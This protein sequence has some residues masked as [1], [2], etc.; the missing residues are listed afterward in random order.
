MMAATTTR[1]DGCCLE[2]LTVLSG[3]SCTS[4]IGA[5]LLY[6]NAAQEPYSKHSSGNRTPRE[7]S[8]GPVSPTVASVRALARAGFRP[9]RA[10]PDQDGIVYFVW[11]RVAES[12]P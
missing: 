10:E 6:W 1:A 9:V 8:A 4:A 12:A 3:A 5:P 11:R 2:R 7:L